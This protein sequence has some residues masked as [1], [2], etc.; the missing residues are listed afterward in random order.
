[1][2]T[3][4]CRGRAGAHQSRH[5]PPPRAAH[6]ERPRPHQAHEQPAA[7]HAGLADPLLRRR[8]RH[9]RQRLH[10][11]PQRRAH[12]RCNGARTATPASRAPI[13]SGCTCRRSWIRS[14]AI[15]SVNVEA[16]SRDP[17]SLLSWTK[18]MLAV[19]KTS[20]AF[21]RGT[22]R[23]LQARQPQDPRLPARV[24]RGHHPV[25]REPVA[26]GA[27]GRAR[28]AGVQGPGA[29]RDARAHDLSADRRPALSADARRATASIGSS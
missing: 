19:R 16:Q 22:R 15:A 4:V 2:Y 6:G 24:R 17:S 12:A 21:G 8:D 10:R 11:R 13:R 7:V 9:G 29:R 23:F 25:R 27:A 28:S 26:L 18:R 5:P 14:T 1:M 20:Q 3:H